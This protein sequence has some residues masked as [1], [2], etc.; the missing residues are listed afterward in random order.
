ML[1]VLPVWA[2]GIVR[3]PC[4]TVRTGSSPIRAR[5]PKHPCACMCGMLGVCSSGHWVRRGRALSRQARWHAA[6]DPPEGHPRDLSWRCSVGWRCPSAPPER[7]PPRRCHRRRSRQTS[8]SSRWTAWVMAIW[9]IAGAR[10]S[11][12]RTSTAWRA[13]ASCSRMATPP[14][15][16]QVPR[17]R[18]SSP[19]DIRRGSASRRTWRLSGEIGSRRCRARRR[20][21]RSTFGIPAIARD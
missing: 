4:W 6:H 14:S 5:R 18:R 16:C 19:A 10:T 1:A 13:K 20:S 11:P 3:P 8:S 15:R 9:A 17:E 7:S 12:L 21:S 2:F